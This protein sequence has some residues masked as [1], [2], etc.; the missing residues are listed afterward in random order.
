MLIVAHKFMWYRYII[1]MY[2]V[3]FGFDQWKYVAKIWVLASNLA[4]FS[5]L[6]KS[7]EN[8]FY[9][10]NNLLFHY[11]FQI[12]PFIIKFFFPLGP[13]KSIRFCKVRKNKLVDFSGPI[14][15]AQLTPT[16]KMR[17]HYLSCTN[18][19]KS[20][21][22]WFFYVILLLFYTFITQNGLAIWIYSS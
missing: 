12:C 20:N 19:R 16:P 21:K 17:S 13:L 5:W 15:S 6:L 22:D 18:S 11:K 10:P 14:M 4:D 7:N 8:Y 3:S 2:L 1:D 9:K